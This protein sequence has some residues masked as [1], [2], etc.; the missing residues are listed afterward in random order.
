MR[1]L[2]AEP[3]L[4]AAR[5]REL[6]L[7]ARAGDARAHDELV[8]AGLRLVALRVRASGLPDP[9]ADDAFQ[10]GALALLSALERFDPD[11]GARLGTYCWSWIVHAVRRAASRSSAEV[12]T[13]DLPEAPGPWDR[14]AAPGAGTEDAA[15]VVAALVARL[16]AAQR[17]AV[18]L[19]FGLGEDGVPLPWHLVAE[20]SGTTPST[21]RRHV[22]E[23]MS[24]L[25][26]GIATVGHRARE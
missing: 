16:P 1:T 14:D 5:E 6:A 23:A 7:A 4:D 25:R 18:T 20:R 13:S 26:D 21:A 10:A 8:R 24:R 12:V 17:T 22:A 15:L 19:R 11:R 2:L 3:P 9:V